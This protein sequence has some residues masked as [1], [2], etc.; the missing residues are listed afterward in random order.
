MVS[1]VAETLQSKDYP[2]TV[3]VDTSDSRNIPH[4]FGVLFAFKATQGLH[5]LEYRKLTIG[6]QSSGCCGSSLTPFA[7]PSI[8]YRMPRF[9]FLSQPG[10][11][12]T[13]HASS[14]ASVA[15]LVQHHTLKLCLK[16]FYG[17]FFRHPVGRTYPVG[18]PS[19]SGNPVAW[20]LQ[21]NIEI[22]TKNPG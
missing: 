2:A 16:P 22:H 1:L 21:H 4:R 13:P 14:R 9:P 11:D 5:L 10:Y 7:S 19:S 18:C 15:L 8:S 6:Y 12:T 3:V 20:S 17:I